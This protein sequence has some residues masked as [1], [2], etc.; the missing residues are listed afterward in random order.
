ML[1]LARLSVRRPK[2]SLAAWLLV[3]IALGLIGLGV[4]GSLSP[5]KTTVAGTQSARA[6]HLATDRFGPSVLVPILLE[7]PKA[8]LDRQGPALVRA[9]AK[10]SDTR[11]LSAWDAGDAGKQMRPRATAALILAAVARTRT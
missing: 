7:G 1:R 6:Q 2:W 10:R 11:V 3:V 5:T 4:T 8:Q 9:L